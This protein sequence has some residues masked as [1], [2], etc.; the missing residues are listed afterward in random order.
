MQFISNIFV[1]LFMNCFKFQNCVAEKSIMNSLMVVFHCDN[2]PHYW[3]NM[4][5]KKTVPFIPGQ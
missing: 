2:V 1:F 3:I 4:F 5:K